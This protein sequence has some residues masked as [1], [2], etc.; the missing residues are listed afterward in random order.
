M[1]D[2]LIHQRNDLYIFT[3]YPTTFIERRRGDSTP[4]F[5]IT[6]PHY[7]SSGFDRERSGSVETSLFWMEF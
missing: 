7:V 5:L 1:L 6:I 3:Q 2:A 4:M